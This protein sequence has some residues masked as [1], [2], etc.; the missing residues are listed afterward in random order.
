MTGGP[1]TKGLTYFFSPALDFM[2]KSS[3]A[4]T[5]RKNDTHS[6]S[7]IFSSGFVLDRYPY[8]YTL[9]AGYQTT[10]LVGKDNKQFVYVRPGLAWDLP[11]KLTF[12]SRGRWLLGGSVKITEGPDGVR[13]DT[14]GK[15][16]GEF[17][18]TRL[19]RRDKA[20]TGGSK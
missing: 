19:F 14:G 4:G 5:F 6:S 20:D 1:Q 10:S 3:V 11:R 17:S 18:I 7:M 12:N 2:E 16:R 13:I 15:L 9:E 8:H